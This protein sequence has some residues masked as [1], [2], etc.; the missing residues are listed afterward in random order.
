MAVLWGLFLL[1]MAT[2]MAG[3][4]LFVKIAEMNKVLGTKETILFLGVL[5]LIGILF[6]SVG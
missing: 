2:F 1:L 3:G 6:I 4:I 5:G